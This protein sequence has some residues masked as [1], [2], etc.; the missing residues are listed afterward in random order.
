MA[1][2]LGLSGVMVWGIERRGGRRGEVP[3]ASGT[4]PLSHRGWRL[5]HGTCPQRKWA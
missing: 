4:G 1:G 5:G 2:G 3:G